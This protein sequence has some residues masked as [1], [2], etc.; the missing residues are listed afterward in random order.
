MW[1]IGNS[2]V[3]QWLGLCVSTAG[4]TGSIPGWG[5]QILQ[6]SWCGQKQKTTKKNVENKS[7]V[8]RVAEVYRT[9]LED[10]VKWDIYFTS[11]FR[12]WSRHVYFVFVSF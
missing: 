4:G 1:R 5:T 6:A 11:I 8:C 10:M 3:V 12:A 7:N 9:D 2:L